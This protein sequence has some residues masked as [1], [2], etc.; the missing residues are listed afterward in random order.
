MDLNEKDIAYRALK[1]AERSGVAMEDA[2]LTAVAELQK[3]ADLLKTARRGI[4]KENSKAFQ[5]F[6]KI[7]QKGKKTTYT[8]DGNAV[9]GF[10]SGGLPGSKK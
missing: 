4:F 1:I 7:K 2:R 9:S 8:V 3:E 5:Q 6:K 10:V